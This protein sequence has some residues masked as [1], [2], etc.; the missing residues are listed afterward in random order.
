MS[1]FEKVRKTANHFSELRADACTYAAAGCS[2]NWQPLEVGNHTGLRVA[3][4]SIIADGECRMKC[5]LRAMYGLQFA[6]AA[7]ARYSAAAIPRLDAVG[8]GQSTGRRC[9]TRSKMT[10]PTMRRHSRSMA[11]RRS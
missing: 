8:I 10:G 9:V 11:F 2:A 5:H 1:A 6:K 4:C 3:L 7:Y